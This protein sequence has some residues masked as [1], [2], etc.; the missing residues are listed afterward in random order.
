MTTPIFRPHRAATAVAAQSCAL[1]AGRRSAP[2]SRCKR[3]AA[4]ASATPLPA[5]AAFTDDATSM[6][7]EPGGAVEAPKMEG[8]GALHVITPSIK[9]RDD[10]SLP[11]ANQPLG[12]DGGDAGGYN[13][14]PNMYLVGADQRAVDVRSRG[15]RAVRPD[16]RVRRRLARPLPGASSREVKTINVNPAISFKVN[17]TIRDRGRRQLPADRRRRS[18]TSVNYSGALLTAAAAN[19]IAPG[20]PTFNAIAGRRAGSIRRRRST[21]TTRPG[22]GTSASPG[23]RRR[24]CALPPPIARK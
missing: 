8:V 10:G 16:D 2:R 18:P 14:V 1:G 12:G 4:A 13:F 19:G 7:C 17:P 3:T 11:A 5:G 22:A 9:F 15:Q 24:S 21:P 6:W 20:T 23:M